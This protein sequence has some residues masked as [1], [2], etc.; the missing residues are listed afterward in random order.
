MYHLLESINAQAVV[1]FTYTRP[2]NWAEVDGKSLMQGCLSVWG[3]ML[4]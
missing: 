3:L 4:P 2:I 1:R